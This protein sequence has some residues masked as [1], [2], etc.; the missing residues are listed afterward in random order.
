MV[1]LLSPTILACW[2]TNFGAYWGLS[3]ALS[4]QGRS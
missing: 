3:Q 4:W 2:A 1:L